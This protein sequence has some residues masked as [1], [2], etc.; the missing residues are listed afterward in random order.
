M[1]R[2]KQM[3]TEVFMSRT[4]NG[5]LPYD[6]TIFWDS[7]PGIEN[8]E[9]VNIAPYVEIQLTHDKDRCQSTMS[10]SEKDR[11]IM[12]LI[13]DR[14]MLS[15]EN[16]Q[17]RTKIRRLKNEN[18]ELEAKSLGLEVMLERISYKGGE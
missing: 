7:I 9:R 17:Y 10:M 11:C 3:A 14:K 2:S 1:N 18:K 13:Q 8:I 16:A 12:Q 6:V 5:T 15:Q 4:E